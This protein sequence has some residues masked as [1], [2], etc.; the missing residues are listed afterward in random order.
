MTHVL[1]VLKHLHGFIPVLKTILNISS[2]WKQAWMC[3]RAEYVRRL[4]GVLLG[5]T[6]VSAGPPEAQCAVKRSVQPQ[7]D[8][9]DAEAHQE[10]QHQVQLLLAHAA[11][12]G[13]A[14]GA[15]RDRAL[16]RDHVLHTVPEPEQHREASLST[17]VQWRMLELWLIWNNWLHLTL[18]NIQIRHLLKYVF[19][20]YIFGLLGLGLCSLLSKSRLYYEYN[21][22]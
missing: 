13:G 3:L 20:H 4:L 10:T 18:K 11:P 8:P 5:L 21:T 17:A 9:A 19:N 6:A 16:V 15:G 22:F 7:Q 14:D 1:R 2:G 12:R